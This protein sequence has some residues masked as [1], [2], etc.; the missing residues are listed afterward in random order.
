MENL[1][2]IF[3][4]IQRSKRSHKTHAKKINSMVESNNKSSSSKNKSPTNPVLTTLLNGILDQTL[5]FPKSN[6]N[7]AR[8]LDFFSTLAA[9]AGETLQSK[10]LDHLYQRLKCTNKTVRQRACQILEGFM[11][12]LSQEQLELDQD[13]IEQFIEN[14]L[15]RLQDRI[16]TIRIAAVEALRH[17]QD[18]TNEKCEIIEQFLFMIENDEVSS[19]RNVVTKNIAL[20]DQTKPAIVQRIRDV[21]SEVRISALNRFIEGA[22]TGTDIRQFS[23]E[24]RL[25]IVTAG[26]NDRDAKVREA[27]EKLLMRWLSLLQNDVSKLFSYLAP[28]ENEDIVNLVA[29]SLADKVFAKSKSGDLHDLTVL[30]QLTPNWH[31]NLSTIPAT[32]LLW[33]YV[34]CK[35]CSL[36]QSKFEAEKFSERVLPEAGRFCQL[37][38]IPYDEKNHLHFKYL[39]LL[40]PF[41]SKTTDI[42]GTKQLLSRLIEMILDP[43]GEC[44]LIEQLLLAFWTISIKDNKSSAEDGT[45]KKLMGFVKELIEDEQGNSNAFSLRKYRAAL[46]VKWIFQNNHY[47]KHLMEDGVKFILSSLQQPHVDLR[48]VAFTSLS[49]LCIV[50][51]DVRKTYQVLIKN[52]AVKEIEDISVRVQA[53]Q[54]LIDLCLVAG[55]DQES[56]TPED[57]MEIDSLITKLMNSEHA[58]LK[59]IAMEGS[60]KLLFS[61]FSTDPH[62]V[63]KLLKFFFIGDDHPVDDDYEEG[64]CNGRRMHQILSVFLQTFLANE[65]SCL[66]VV[67]L[68]ISLFISEFT[69]SIRDEQ[70][71]ATSLA[72]VMLEGIS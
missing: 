35:Y 22:G 33:V 52:I 17:L 19:V 2:T 40:A 23:K 21:E 71:E 31:A 37:L 56:F 25:E 65:Q 4:D 43:S 59:A 1:L 11:S 55:E 44:D 45:V 47:R 66:E 42:D 28:A 72:Q 38:S 3:E 6:P 53:V 58:E 12:V 54:G 7:I 5:L 69:T 50:D 16:P 48:A 14:V 68:S 20:C 34:K 10:L 27:T 13:T 41:V 51:A 18:V 26:L 9:A 61:G 32:D 39:L 15:Q 8:I 60:V 67:R 64:T 36:F 63:S 24:L 46:I 49:V 30:E 70:I 62:M 57:R 29:A